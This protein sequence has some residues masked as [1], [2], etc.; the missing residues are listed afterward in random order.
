[1]GVFKPLTKKQTRELEENSTPYIMIMD[2]AQTPGDY[3]RGFHNWAQDDTTIANL[4][5]YDT[6]DYMSGR[7]GMKQTYYRQHT[8]RNAVWGFSFNDKEYLIYYS[9][10]GLALQC[11]MDVDSNDLELVLNK[12]IGCWVKEPLREWLL[13]GETK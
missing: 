6:V 12:I 4:G 9:I 7:L 5:L 2:R 11:A 8:M 3:I 10:D 1:M 13:S